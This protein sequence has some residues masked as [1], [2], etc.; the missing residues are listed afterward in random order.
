[1]MVYANPPDSHFIGL[2]PHSLLILRV[3][4]A[5]CVGP[6]NVPPSTAGRFV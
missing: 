1:M 5:Y 3:A 6:F 4:F 2:Y